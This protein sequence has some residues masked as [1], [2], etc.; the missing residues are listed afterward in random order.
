MNEM[1]AIRK[2]QFRGP[3]ESKDLGP[4]VEMGVSGR[5]VS[6][7]GPLLSPSPR[8][9][10]L[11]LDDAL[12]DDLLLADGPKVSIPVEMALEALADAET[13]GG[14]GADGESGAHSGA[15]SRRLRTR[16]E[17]TIPALHGLAG[18]VPSPPSSAA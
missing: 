3:W 13:E 1:R 5:T 14:H 18:H 8:D 6:S 2:L 7:G 4:S 12:L 10:G 16:L 9:L 15:R 11:L 17:G